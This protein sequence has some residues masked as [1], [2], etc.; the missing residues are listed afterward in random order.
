[1][2]E[3]AWL[4]VLASM[5]AA[6]P[7]RAGPPLDPVLVAPQDGEPIADHRARGRC[8]TSSTSTLRSSAASSRTPPRRRARPT[9][10]A[11]RRATGRC[12]APRPAAAHDRATTTG[13]RS[14]RL[15]PQGQSRHLRPRVHEQGVRAGQ[16]PAG[17]RQQAAEIA[18]MLRSGEAAAGVRVVARRRCAE[19]SPRAFVVAT[20][21]R[22]LPHPT[23]FSSCAR[24]AGNYAAHRAA[25][26]PA[27][28]RCSRRAARVATARTARA[29]CSTTVSSRSAR[30][31]GRRPTRTGSRSR[32]AS[33]GPRWA[34]R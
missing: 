3:R 6:C 32:T 5:S 16:E 19:A 1:M 7:R 24:L 33:P 21:E 18:A 8:S 14:V 23:T 31:Q 28:R 13:S 27:A 11:G 25:T 12:P 34:V 26:P 22:K 17:R 30:T 2:R 20:R 10:R 29:S 15:G 9:E 4:V